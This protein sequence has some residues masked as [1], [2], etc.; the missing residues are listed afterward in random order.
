M[1]TSARAAAPLR[2]SGKS[3][4]VAGAPDHPGLRFRRWRDEADL[5][6]WVALVNASWAADGLPFRTGPE[7]EGTELRHTAGSDLELDVL[8]A[9]LDGRIVGF[10]RTGFETASD[11]TRGHW[12]SIMVAPDAGVPGLREALL[13]WA[14]ARQRERATAE[15]APGRTADRVLESWANEAETGWLALLG[16][17]GYRPVRWFTEMVRETLDD[18]PDRALPEGLEIRPV[19]AE[20]VRVILA[21]KDEAFR[22][23][24]GHVPQT[25]ED[26]QAVLAH[27][28]TDLSLWAVAWDGDQ[29]AGLVIGHELVDDNAA[30]GWRRGWL[31]SVGTRRSWRQR[32]LASALCVQAMRQMRDAGLTSAGLGVDTESAT[33]ALGLYE[34]LGFRLDVRAVVVRKPLEMSSRSTRPHVRVGTPKGRAEPLPT[35]SRQDRG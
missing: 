9:E 33:G 20:D 35:A 30:F 6:G 17:R 5:D 16:A 2:A 26:I 32:G 13:D 19:Q 12:V 31:A 22:D 25:E 11:G 3:I 18:L 8:L 7:Q 10:A 15:P 24:W 4:E 28:H 1:T 14:E 27:P 23:H 34:R 21:A 29:V